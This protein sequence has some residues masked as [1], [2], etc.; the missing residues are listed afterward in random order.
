M[1][2]PTYAGSGAKPTDPVF[3]AIEVHRAAYLEYERARDLAEK[4][5]HGLFPEARGLP[6][7]EIGRRK[8]GRIGRTCSRE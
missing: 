2:T 7:I 5:Y 3:A 4:A 8:I 1:L 6:K